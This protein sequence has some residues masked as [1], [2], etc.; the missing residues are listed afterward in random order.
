MR[1]SGHGDPTIIFSHGFGCDQTAWADVAPAFENEARVVLFDH[2]GSGLS[3]SSAYDAANYASLDGYA[4]DVVELADTLALRDT[5]FVGHSVGAMIGMLAAVKSPVSIGRMVMLCPSPRYID[6]GDYVGGF[7]RADI[8]DLLLVL[9]SN[10]LAWSRA[11]AP[12]MMGNGERPE[13]G[14][15]LADSFCRTDPEIA[16]A[17]ARVTFLSDL[18]ADLPHLDVPTL[19]LQTQSDMIAPLQVGDYMRDNLP[20]GELVV[21]EASGHCPHMSAPAETIAAIKRFLAF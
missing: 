7:S 14:E 9:E 16:K 19:I 13:L 21:M 18:R 2:V 10:F 4:E 11:T 3:D 6:D 5:V 15:A 1:V 17:F 12:Q 8:D 20:R